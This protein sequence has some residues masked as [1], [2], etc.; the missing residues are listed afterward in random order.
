M[1]FGALLD[2]VPGL[3][4]A[5]GALLL[6]AFGDGEAQ[7]VA[8]VASSLIVLVDAMGEELGHAVGAAFAEAFASTV[9]IVAATAKTPSMRKLPNLLRITD[10]PQRSSVTRTARQ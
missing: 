2:I 10:P 1:V 9:A 6:I 3:A 7:F 5:P 4:M 8:L